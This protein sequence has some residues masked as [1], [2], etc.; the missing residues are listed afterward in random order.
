MRVALHNIHLLP[1]LQFHAYVYGFLRQGLVKVL[2][3]SDHNGK[4]L[5]RSLYRLTRHKQY[6]DKYRGIDWNEF[7]FAFSAG[8]LRRKADVLLNLNLMYMPKLDTEFSSGVSRFDGLKI[9]HV[10]DYFWY[11][12]G[13]EL[14]RLLQRSGVDHLF[15]YA[16]HD[17]YCA[18]FQSYFPGYR[19]KVWGIPFGFAR[20]F[21]PLKP[22]IERSNK[23]V[24]V[25]SVNPLRPLQDA[26]HNYRETADFFP[27][28]NWFHKFR[29]QLVLNKSQL[30]GVMDSMLPEFPAIKDFKYDLVAKF[31]D[32]RMFVTCESI[33]FFP[34]AKVFE[35]PACGTTL[36]C[37]DHDCNREYGFEDGRNCVMYQP[38]NIND[39]VDKVDWYQRNELRLSEIAEKGHR[40]VTGNYSHENVAN[41]IWDTTKLIWDRGGNVI[42][43]PLGSRLL[44]DRDGAGGT[45]AGDATHA[46]HVCR[47]SERFE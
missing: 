6:R 4:S 1:D 12:P 35:G 7:D 32:Y 41:E 9:F 46:N 38:Y 14:Y 19:G 3:F 44:A 10:G 34:S 16:M 29:R 47:K 40:F 20:R 17:R 31:N 39:F 8:D 36:V 15:G 30:A 5:A 13:S 27:D 37:A 28:E 11:R 2:Y 25:G 18:Y 24:A 42:A 43:S 26:V 45:G 22:F 33:Y 21:Q 23:A